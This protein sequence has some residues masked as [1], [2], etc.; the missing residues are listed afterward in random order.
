MVV[1]HT[2]KVRVWTLDPKL[3]RQYHYFVG[4][5]RRSSQGGRVSGSLYVLLVTPSGCLPLSWTLAM[6]PTV[7]SDGV[8]KRPSVVLTQKFLSSR[9]TVPCE[10]D[11]LQVGSLNRPLPISTRNMKRGKLARRI[12]RGRV[13][14]RYGSKQRIFYSHT[15]VR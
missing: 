9:G 5:N 6:T 8:R 7:W 11:F 13:V 4:S 14:E 1:T 2:S 3:R 10:G 15:Q 12:R